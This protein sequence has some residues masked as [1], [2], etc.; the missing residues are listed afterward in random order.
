VLERAVDHD[1]LVSLGWARD[2]AEAW[3]A[4]GDEDLSPVR[5]RRIDRG[6]WLDVEGIHGPVRARQHPRFRRTM[7]SLD[8]PAVG[9][10][11][12]LR[13]D[14]GG[15][16]PLLEQLLPRRT[17]LVRN[18]GG[19][20][21][22]ARPQAVAANMETVLVVIPLSE[23]L[24][25]RRLDRFLSIAAASGADVALALTKL[26]DCDDV[27][28][29]LDEA[30]RAAPGVPAHPLSARTGEGMEA[31]DPYLA[32]GRTVA[33]LGMS[34]VGKS[35]LANRLHGSEILAT[36]TLRADG[37]GR[38]T[39]T[40][41]EL[42][43]LPGGGLLIDTPGVRSVGLW[44]EAEEGA[45]DDIETL[46]EQCRFSD[47]AHETEPDCAVLAALE[48][49][50]LSRERWDSYLTLRDELEH[51][52]QRQDATARAAETRRVRAIQRDL[53]EEPRSKRR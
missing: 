11:G 21:E 28:T 25:T 44:E 52:A 2:L 5:V 4:L 7:D 23:G 8:L 34:G 51:L 33:L 35:T 19:D 31:L 17:V 40:H 41:R 13:V 16:P 46:I 43:G 39:T 12:V 49:G 10:W 18:A 47:C 15:G 1:P 50:G 42:V 24:N 3:A 14:T 48:A 27:Q 30:R 22:R 36:D 32:P 29:V 45:F 9:D 37:R 6:G 26:D 38:H 20:D 53:R